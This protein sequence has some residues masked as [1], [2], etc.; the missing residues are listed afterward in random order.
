M[1]VHQIFHDGWALNIES[2]SK[3]PLTCEWNL[4][5]S[6]AIY[7]NETPF[8]QW[9]IISVNSRSQDVGFTAAVAQVDSSGLFS[10]TTSS[11]CSW[12][13]TWAI[14]CCYTEHR[15][16]PECETPERNMEV[17]S[18]KCQMILC[19]CACVGWKRVVWGSDW[20]LCHLVLEMIMLRRLLTC[21]SCIL[22]Q[23]SIITCCPDAQRWMSLSI[24]SS[25]PGQK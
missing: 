24:W 5:S 19:K 15:P 25:V 3:K 6:V 12:P 8:L 23:A 22:L 16:C 20:A 11:T 17:I 4:N 2:T 1:Q 14:I 7:K 9:S 21:Y 18:L 13:I 10:G